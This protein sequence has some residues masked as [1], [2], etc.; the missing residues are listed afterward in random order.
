MTLRN[1]FREFVPIV[2]IFIIVNALLIS[3]RS[4]LARM[5]ADQNVLIAANLLIFVITFFS[6]LLAKKGL[7]DPNPHAFVRSV[8][9]SM[10]LKLFVCIIAAFIYIA[11]NNG[12]IN[13]PALFGGMGLY[14][15]YTFT[16]VSILTKML[17]NKPNE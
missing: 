5:K 6:F 2:L 15:V 12:T 7:Q 1:R 11:A 17:R 10:M 4:W 13:K 3:G 8:Y 16:E 14:L 9:S